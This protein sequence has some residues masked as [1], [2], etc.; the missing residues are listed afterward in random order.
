MDVKETRIITLRINLNECIS[1][2][3]SAHIE[4]RQLVL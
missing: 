1:K 2:S 4:T 3:G